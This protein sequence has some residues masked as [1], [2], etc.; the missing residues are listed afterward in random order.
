MRLGRS[1][2][3]R[4][5]SSRGS[6]GRSRGRSRLPSRPR[7]TG[8]GFPSGGGLGSGGGL[9]AGGCGPKAGG[10]M[11]LIIIVVVFL[12]IISVGGGLPGGGGGDGGG[13]AERTDLVGAEAV[14]ADDL[15]PAEREAL[16]RFADDLALDVNAYWEIQ[17]PETYNARYEPPEFF[18]FNPAKPERT[19]TCGQRLSPQILANNAIY[20]PAGDY[21]TWDEYY[22][23]PKLD[24]NFGRASLGV[25]LSHEWGHAIQGPVRANVSGRT[26]IFKELQADCFAGAWVQSV[27]NGESTTFSG[28]DQ[29]QLDGAVAGFLLLRDPPGTDPTQQGAHGS[30]FDRVGSF[31]DGLVNGPD[32][33]ASYRED[34]GDRPRI[35]PLEFSADDVD[36]GNLSYD[37]AV[38]VVINA[39]NEF[40]GATLL[41]RLGEEQLGLDEFRSSAN[42]V[43]SCPASSTRADGIVFY[44]PETTSISWDA[45]SLE[46][47]HNDVGDFSV[48]QL[49]AH[50][51]GHAILDLVGAS[52]SGEELE[53]AA[54]CLAGAWSAAVNQ[55]RLEVPDPQNRSSSV[56]LE[57]SPGDLDE[58]LATMLRFRHP[59]RDGSSD[60][61][62]F[63]RTRSF[64]SGF[65][66]GAD[67]CLG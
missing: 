52:G 17:Y 45:D 57:M 13:T 43:P 47:I 21:V 55:G 8:G 11:G 19:L 50:E 58:G 30:A 53:I 7:R 42:G 6:S 33:C 9:P 56:P 5:G 44:C 49:F 1:G 18:A 20:C 61:D 64:Q 54:D 14:T 25:V 35:T 66:S 48:S 39:L 27:Q 4:G 22:L 59:D 60:A 29:E 24:R 31:E 37:I 65:F 15:E 34:S 41:D 36:S 3:A 32:Y 2:G 23:F 40:Y 26:T 10:G 16:Q 46:K 28:F 38:D 62:L 63:E 67:S 12:F 51:Y